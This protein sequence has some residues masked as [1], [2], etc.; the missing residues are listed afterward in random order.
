MGALAQVVTPVSTADAS[1]GA[2]HAEILHSYLSTPMANAS[3]LAAQRMKT[4]AFDHKPS[5]MRY[6]LSLQGPNLML[7]YRDANDP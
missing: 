4:G 6:A 5:G 2:C 7:T 1:C 3:G